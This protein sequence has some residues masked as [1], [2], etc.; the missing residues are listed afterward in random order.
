MKHKW[1]RYR[2]YSDYANKGDVFLYSSQGQLVAKYKVFGNTLK[3]N[4]LPIYEG[5]KRIGIV[6]PESVEWEYCPDLLT[7]LED[8]PVDEVARFVGGYVQRSLLKSERKYELVDHLGNVRVVIA[9]QRIQF[10]IYSSKAF[11]ER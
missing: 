4:Y 5:S 10:M 11:V 6:E 8:V 2:F 1:F 3:L 7:C 9:N